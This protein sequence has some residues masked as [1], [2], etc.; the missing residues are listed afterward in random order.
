MGFVQGDTIDLAGIGL[1]SGATI[2][3][4]NVLSVQGTAINLQLDPALDYTGQTALV[5]PDGN[6]GTDVTLGPVPS[7]TITFSEYPVGT[8][9]PVYTYPDNTVDVLGQIVE[10]G[11]QPAS[12]SV[13]AEPPTLL[14]RSGL[15]RFCNAGDTCRV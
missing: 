13:A 11:A 6:G 10:D 3:A 5:M 14:S 8:V 15:Y 9:N 7:H 12:P 4:S 2:T 1:A